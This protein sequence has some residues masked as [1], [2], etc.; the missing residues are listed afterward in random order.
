M[1]VKQ[2]RGS[3][4]AIVTPFGSAGEVDEV[5]FRRLLDWHLEEGT[6]AVVVAGT[7]G[8]ASTLSMEEQVR[9]FEVAVDQVLRVR[10]P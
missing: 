3:I 1:K 2:F 5:G 8:E 7:T 4:V 6:D 10:E 9:L